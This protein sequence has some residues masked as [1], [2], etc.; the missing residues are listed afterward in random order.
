MLFRSN[1]TKLLASKHKSTIKSGKAEREYT[2]IMNKYGF[3][4]PMTGRLSRPPDDS[5]SYGRDDKVWTHITIDNN[6]RSQ[7]AEG[8]ETRSVGGFLRKYLNKF[9]KETE[10]LLEK[11]KSLKIRLRVNLEMSKDIVKN[12]RIRR[13]CNRKSY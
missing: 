9:E 3:N 1:A 12:V 5:I 2:S 13:S 4:L 11:R 7:D 6:T 10:K 8:K